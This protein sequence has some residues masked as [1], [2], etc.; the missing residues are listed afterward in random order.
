MLISPKLLLSPHLTP[1]QLQSWV[2]DVLTPL[3]N[4]S[5]VA[6][7]IAKN[8]HQVA[9]ALQEALLL[10][11]QGEGLRYKLREE[12]NSK[13]DSHNLRPMLEDVVIFRTSENR[14]RFGIIKALLPKNVCSVQCMK[15]NSV[16]ILDKHCRLLVLLFRE[17]EWHSSGTPKSLL[18]KT[19]NYEA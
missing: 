12:N 4:P 9:N 5:S 19:S 18:R 16:Q 13:A 15:N 10:Y 11:L 1:A 8:H 7:L 2:I 6:S 14:I 17:S 3:T